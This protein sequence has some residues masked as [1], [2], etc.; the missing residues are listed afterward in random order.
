[1]KPCVPILVLLSVGAI[2]WA[3]RVGA[4]AQ[5]EPLRPDY[6]EMDL[7]GARELAA[8]LPFETQDLSA[9]RAVWPTE[10]TDLGFGGSY[11]NV[12][13][14]RGYSIGSVEALLYRG[15]VARYVAVIRSGSHWKT[16]RSGIIE[17]WSRVGGPAFDETEEGLRIQ[18]TIP[19]VMQAYK[20]HVAAA[21]G[22]LRERAVSPELA[23]AYEALLDPMD[24]ATVSG[25]HA[26]EE[27]STLVAAD[28]QDLVENVLRGY[29]PG[30]RVSAALALL[31]AQKAGLSLSRGTRRSIKKVLGLDIALHACVFDICSNL[32][33]KDALEWFGSDLAF[34]QASQRHNRSR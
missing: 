12:G 29:N 2:A 17:E 26:S 10:Q 18:R 3:A 34:P 32:P 23:A 20:A 4:K 19:R 16:L 28:R 25:T 6:V 5:L 31:E 30:A 8:L 11:L 21:L 22:P 9:V 15:K 24:N 33:A 7:R 1:M 27:L 13:R 14:G